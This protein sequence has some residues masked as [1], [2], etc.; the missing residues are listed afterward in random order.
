MDDFGWI[1]I[2][3]YSELDL[4]E[5]GAYV[6]SR[7][8][9][10]ILAG[11]AYGLEPV[12]LWEIGMDP[13]PVKEMLAMVRVN[14]AHN[15]WFDRN[16]L[17]H[18][19]WCNRPVSDWHCTMAQAY[20]HQLPASLEALGRAMGLPLDERKKANGKKLIRL[21]C[22]PQHGGIRYTKQDLPLE[23]DEF[24][25]YAKGDVTAMREIYRRMP[26]VNLDVAHS[27]I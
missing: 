24:R 25:T 1:D 20:A 16:C 4:K 3:T 5:V 11:Y 23:W 18:A 6:Y 8:C 17:G 26:R 22:K 19:G 10:I 15:V 14:I 12:E 27:P 21:F 9:E 2:E 13:S 7:N